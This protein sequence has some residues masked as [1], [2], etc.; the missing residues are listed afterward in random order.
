MICPRGLL[1]DRGIESVHQ[2]GADDLIGIGEDI[3]Y[4]VESIE[5]IVRKLRAALPVG[6]A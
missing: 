2:R 4:V 1:P 5:P 3:D 6:V